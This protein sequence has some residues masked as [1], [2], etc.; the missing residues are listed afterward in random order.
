MQTAKSF[1]S[2]VPPTLSW[3]EYNAYGNGVGQ[4]LSAFTRVVPPTAEFGEPP[5]ELLAQVASELQSAEDAAAGLAQRAGVLTGAAME[6]STGVID[7]DGMN[8]SGSDDDM[9]AL[10]ENMHDDDPE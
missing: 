9:P 10:E 1:T 6:Q 5:A 4:P 2:N 3:H 7:V 8:D